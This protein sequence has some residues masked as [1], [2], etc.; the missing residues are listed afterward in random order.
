[1]AKLHPRKLMEQ[2]NEVT[3]Q[4]VS[5]P[6]ADGKASALVGAVRWKPGRTLETSCRGEL[7]FALLPGP[8]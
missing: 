8:L 7:R 6:R 5:E 4:S 1:M 2:A 3:Q